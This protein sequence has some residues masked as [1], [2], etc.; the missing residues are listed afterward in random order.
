MITLT[1][2]QS[3]RDEMFKISASIDQLQAAY[4]RI[5]PLRTKI[6]FGGIFADNSSAAKQTAATVG[7]SAVSTAKKQ[8]ARTRAI[9]P[10]ELS[11]DIEDAVRRSVSGLENK[12]LMPKGGGLQ[13]LQR[14]APLLEEMAIA[15]PGTA[16][17]MGALGPAGKKAMNVATGIHEGFEVGSKSKAPIHSHADADV[18]MKEHNLLRGATGEGADELRSGLGGLRRGPIG[19]GTIL[20]K[21]IA[22][23]YGPEVAATFQYGAPGSMKITKAMRKDM[24]RSMSPTRPKEVAG[25]LAAK[26]W[27]P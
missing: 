13:T 10:G 4:R 22:D 9:F 7:P 16:K 8:M 24:Q 27:K 15:A 6:R 23:R 5:A 17:A 2:L 19:E 25:E 21:M 11:K 18:I 3:F 26:H 20:Q 1:S 14:S 12:I